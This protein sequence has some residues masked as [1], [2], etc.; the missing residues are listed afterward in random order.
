MTVNR[1]SAKLMPKSI[2]IELNIIVDVLLERKGFEASLAVIE[3]GERKGYQLSVS[4]HMVTTLA[5]LLEAAQLPRVAVAEYVAWLLDTFQIIPT[6]ETL[7]RAALSSRLTDYEDAVVEQAALKADA[8]III[9]RN[10]RDFR[11]SVVPAQ[12]P[13]AYLS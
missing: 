13:E 2:F 10:I 5:Y 6:G 8:A 1:E 11:H 3:L 9:T 12:T 7:F 4:A